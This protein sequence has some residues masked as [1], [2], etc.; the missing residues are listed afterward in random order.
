MTL[1]LPVADLAVILLTSAGFPSVLVA[2]QTNLYFSIFNKRSAEI[3]HSSDP[4]KMSMLT[5]SL[6]LFLGHSIRLNSHTETAQ[7]HRAAPHPALISTNGDF[8]LA[9]EAAY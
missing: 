1:A 3:H 5:Q 6:C 4:Y 9:T 8:R 2:G 7:V